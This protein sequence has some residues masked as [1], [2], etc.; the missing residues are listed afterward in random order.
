[1]RVFV[2]SGAPARH[3][4][5]MEQHPGAQEAAGLAAGEAAAAA[6]RPRAAVGWYVGDGREE[7]RWAST[8]AS[9]YYR[10]TT[11]S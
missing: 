6:E 2:L 7:P 10:A 3:V 8:G 9:F 1:M 4:G 11:G 5:H